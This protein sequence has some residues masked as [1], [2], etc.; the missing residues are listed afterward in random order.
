M[1]RKPSPQAACAERS[2]ADGKDNTNKRIWQRIRL[3]HTTESRKNRRRI[4]PKFQ[5]CQRHLE[6]HLPKEQQ[7]SGQEQAGAFVYRRDTRRT[8]CGGNVAIFL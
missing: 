8:R 7:Y 2:K 6:I 3:F 5:Q 1:A 4:V